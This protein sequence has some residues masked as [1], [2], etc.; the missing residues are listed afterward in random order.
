[1]NVDDIY[2]YIGPAQKFLCY[3]WDTEGPYNEE[4]QVGDLILLLENSNRSLKFY[5]LGQTWKV[6]NLR[7][8]TIGT[9]NLYLPSGWKNRWTK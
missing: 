6:K 4:I 8:E 7:T 2:E 1:M 5:G 9:T 3:K